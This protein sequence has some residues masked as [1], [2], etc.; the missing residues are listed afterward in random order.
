MCTQPNNQGWPRQYEPHKNG[1]SMLGGGS[2][3]DRRPGHEG[4]LQDGLAYTGHVV[5]IAPT[6]SKI[7]MSWINT[8]VTLFSSSRELSRGKKNRERCKQ[9]LK[10]GGN[11]WFRGIKPMRKCLKCALCLLTCRGRPFVWKW[12]IDLC[13]VNWFQRLL[14]S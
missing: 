5:L 14:R 9:T 1:A 6:A 10:P 13:S 4:H 8:H 11:C 7:S 12:T 3:I 2:D